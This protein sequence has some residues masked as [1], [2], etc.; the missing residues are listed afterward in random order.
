[1]QK[2]PKVPLS[3][4]KTHLYETFEIHFAVPPKRE[5]TMHNS[6]ATDELRWQR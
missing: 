5:L 2:G 4:L 3:E 1:M 6:I